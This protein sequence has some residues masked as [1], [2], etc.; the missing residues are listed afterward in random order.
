MEVDRF[1]PN[2]LTDGYSLSDAAVDEID[3]RGAK[4]VITI[5]NGSGAIPEIAELA[6]R[7][8]DVIVTD[9]HEMGEALP[10]AVA[11]VNP[12]RDGCEYPFKLLAGV[13]VAFKL[14]SAYC[15][16]LSAEKKQQDDFRRYVMDALALAAMGTISDVV[17]LIGENRILAKFGLKAI[18]ASELPGL[19]ALCE[20]SKVNRKDVGTWDV[21]YRI[22]P[23]INAAG[24]MGD[25]AASL[26]LLLDSSPDSAK[27]A[28]RRLDRANAKRQAVE[29]EILEVCRERVLAD[30]F[31]EQR[32]TIVLGDDAWHRGVLGIVAAKLAG[33]FHRP[34]ILFAFED[35]VGRGS[36]RSVQGF[37]VLN[38]IRGCSDRLRAFG[39]HAFAAGLEI[40]R[41]QFDAF[42]EEFDRETSALNDHRDFVPTLRADLELPL[43]SVDRELLHDLGRLAPFGEQNPAPVFVT[44]DVRVAGPPKSMGRKNRHLQMWINQ[45]ETSFRAIGFGMAAWLERLHDSSRIDIAYHPRLAQWGGRDE[46]ELLLK[47]LRETT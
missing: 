9:H 7:G 43:A 24:R 35:G 39:G 16:Y 29:R 38:A 46:V 40:A 32:R 2:R 18:G 5:D 8:I 23:R 28:A 11:I 37:N 10:E 26:D 30:G 34:A 12:K 45:G 41:D 19:R 36:A 31:L 1:I 3:R 20:V 33:E 25:S 22:G 44:R 21:G 17:P 27:R 6:R 4:V 15:R 14:M 47:D 42:V 13:G